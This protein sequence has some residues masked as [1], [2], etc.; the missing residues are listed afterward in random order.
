MIPK[1][2]FQ[3]KFWMSSRG[4][5]NKGSTFL[6]VV[7]RNFDGNWY[8]QLNAHNFGKMKLTVKGSTNHKLKDQLN[9]AFLRLVFEKV[10]I[11]C[12]DIA[13]DDAKFVSKLRDLLLV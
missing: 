5:A 10:L 11:L 3:K 13:L 2:K 7:K 1:L 8:R 6:K 4:F 12:I 9:K